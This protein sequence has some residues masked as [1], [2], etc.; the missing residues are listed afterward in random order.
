M[1]KSGWTRKNPFVA[2]M[3]ENRTLSGPKSA[4]DIRHI[5]FDQADSG[6]TYE[7]GDAL[8][9]MPENG[10]DLVKRWLRRLGATH[11]TNVCGKP[12][13]DR[14]ATEFEIV[15]PPRD[16][17]RAIEPSNHWQGTMNSPML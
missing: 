17:V 2:T 1:E 16:L 3:S 4:K 9:V 6:V 10:S 5:A 7:A 12:L 8:G 13:G 11:D 15:T 14:Q